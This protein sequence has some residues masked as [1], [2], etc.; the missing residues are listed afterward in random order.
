MSDRMNQRGRSI[1]VTADRR[2]PPAHETLETTLK[3]VGRAAVRD[4]LGHDPS[5][6]GPP[7]LHAH[8][9]HAF[10]GLMIYDE[11]E[12]IG[13]TLEQGIHHRSVPGKPATAQ[14]FGSQVPSDLD[15]DAEIGTTAEL[16]Y[17]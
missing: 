10:G 1:Q 13:R 12:S 17:N 11:I 16:G 9:V 7:A 15:A 3:M 6:F 5:P 2:P 14:V 8:R 4:P